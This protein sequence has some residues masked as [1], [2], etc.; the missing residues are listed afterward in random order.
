MLL[1]LTEILREAR[2]SSRHHRAMVRIVIYSLH[3]KP[4]GDIFPSQHVHGV[5]IND[6]SHSGLGDVA[7]RPGPKGF[8]QGM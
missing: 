6:H 1:A 5:H 7:F 2:N 3:N 4:S 8:G